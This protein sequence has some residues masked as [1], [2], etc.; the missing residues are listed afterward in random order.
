[1]KQSAVRAARKEQVVTI[2]PAPS[3]AGAEIL[4]LTEDDFFLLA[5]RRVVTLPNRVWHATSDSQAV[6]M[7]MQTPYAVVLVDAALVANQL[8]QVITRLKQ[9]LPDLGFVVAGDLEHRAAAQALVDSELVEGFVVKEEAAERLAGVLEAGI[10]RHL[11]LKT[12]NASRAGKSGGKRGLVLGGVAAV[13]VAGAVGGWLYLS[14][15]AAV[16]S[17]ADVVPAARPVDSSLGVVDA[18]LQKA[19]DAFDAG[20]Y[21]DPKGKSA[22]DY[23]RAALAADKTNAEA[24]D[25]IHRV[26]EVML[27][28]AE[29]AMLE[30]KPRDAQAS[31]KLAK[32]IEP[33]HPRITFLE[34]QIARE[35]ERTA[36]VQQEAAR[37]DA[38]SQKLSNYMRLANERL[39]QDRL[40]DPANDNARHYLVLARDVDSGSVLVTQGLR[41]LA[42]KM[43]QKSQQSASRGDLESA[44]QWLTQARQLG[45]SGIDFARI[46][47]DNRS[48]QRTKSNDGERL[49]GLARERIAQGQLIE[50]DNDSA[51]HYVS[52]LRRQYSDT[53]GLGPVVDTL[54]DQLLQRATQAAEKSDAKSGQDYLDEARSIGASGPAYDAAAALVASARLRA[55]ALSTVKPVRDN[56]V[57]KSFTPDYPAKA[58]RRKAE[59]FVD[60]HFTAGITGD[61]KDVVVVKSEPAELFDDAAIRAIKRWKFK[62]AEVNGEPVEQRLSLRIT[63]QLTD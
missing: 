33:A 23:Y 52:Q 12:E 38:Q 31:V 61:V 2:A 40:V 14:K 30:S 18:E 41:T 19:R 46:E 24:A 60:L 6:D 42:N 1:V 59:G 16:D 26:A 57:V 58:Q 34:Q 39:S 28:R 35:L 48:A 43:V 54:R 50:P 63:F 45:V 27:A 36:A 47:R 32:A 15:P 10:N 37:L 20:H 11:E 9:Q 13:V 51:R 8:E 56:M 22:L 53:A 17:V 25:G 29:A 44:D 3:G 49:L 5:V 62:P 4:A 55:E 21:T 7:L